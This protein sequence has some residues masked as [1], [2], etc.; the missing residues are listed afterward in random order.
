MVGVCLYLQLPGFTQRKHRGKPE[1]V[2]PTHRDVKL[3]PR[4]LLPFNQNGGKKSNYFSVCLPLC[5]SF[6]LSPALSARLT[7]R[8][9]THSASGIKRFKPTF[10][11]YTLSQFMERSEEGVWREV[12]EWLLECA[13][14]RADLRK[15]EKELKKKSLLFWWS[16][17]IY[18][19]CLFSGWRVIMS[20]HFSGEFD[21]SCGGRP[22]FCLKHSG[23]WKREKN[24]YSPPNLNDWEPGD[25]DL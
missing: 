22:L 10:L 21:E 15:T 19:N 1:P 14:V 20:V 25:I 8:Q 3:M 2:K 4:L 11:N 7:A 16:R 24:S 18:H 9:Q 13:G 23:I 6:C 5:L 17:H 12:R